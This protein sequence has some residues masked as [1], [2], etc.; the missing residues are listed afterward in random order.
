M[1]KV[2]LTGSIGSGKTLVARILENLGI[3]VFY[4]D[5]EAKMLLR[6]PEVKAGIVHYFG[7]R[8]LDEHSQIV[9]KRLAAIVFNDPPSLLKLNAIIHPRVRQR[10]L[11]WFESRGP[12]PYAVQEAAILFESGFS[13]ECDTIVTVSAPEEIRIQR[14]MERDHID[15][16][17]V[18]LRMKNQLTDLEKCKRA[19]FVITNDGKR[20]VIPQVLKVHG[21]LIRK[22]NESLNIEH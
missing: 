22:A 13:K 1:L 15:R 17:E 8:I 10:L 3:E 16:E 9:N 2:G 21:E 6:D 18:L 7:D 19:D 4:A 12:I 5:T 11:Q 20:M 14:V